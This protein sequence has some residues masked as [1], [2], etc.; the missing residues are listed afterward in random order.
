MNFFKAFPD[1]T[2]LPG[3]NRLYGGR[4]AMTRLRLLGDPSELL[5]VDLGPNGTAFTFEASSIEVDQMT[6]AGITPSDFHLIDIT[7]GG[8]GEELSVL[9]KYETLT[10]VL[11]DEVAPVLEHD[12]EGML[13]TTRQ[14]VA[15]PG[16]NLT[17]Y[18]FIIASSASTPG[19][20]DLLLQF[21]NQST[22]AFTRVNLVYRRAYE[23]S[24][25]T[26]AASELGGLVIRYPFNPVGDAVHVVAAQRYRQS[27]V[28][29]AP[30]ALN[31][32]R[33]ILVADVARTLFF[34]GDQTPGRHTGPLVEF[35]REWADVPASRFEYQEIAYSFP[36][37]RSTQAEYN[38]YSALNWRLGFTRKV[39][40]QIALDFFR[41]GVGAAYASEDDIPRIAVTI[42]ARAANFVGARVS[43]LQ[44]LLSDSDAISGPVSWN[45]L[46]TVPT[47]TAYEALVTAGA[48][49]LV[50]DCEV[51]RYI[52]NI[53]VRRTVRVKAI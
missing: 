16:I 11:V 37:F 8:G 3:L 19:N 4:W 40:A 21:R 31:A 20:G 26:G 45:G 49:S 17:P 39:N 53:F 5:P 42:W 10:N 43:A 22:D 27:A 13:R 2:R 14:M 24:T 46:L 25:V 41:V 29:Y 1:E 28:S 47:R 6:A 34:V 23:A 15:K 33:S 44:I 36:G 38:Q 30:L 32:A 51:D 52:G 12:S 35:V 50:V 9:Y 7:T 48:F 18:G